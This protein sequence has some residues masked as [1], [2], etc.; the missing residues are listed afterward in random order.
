MMC[1]KFQIETWVIGRVK[2]GEEYSRSRYNARIE[3]D[4][5]KRRNQSGEPTINVIQNNYVHHPSS[6][7]VGAAETTLGVGEGA[8]L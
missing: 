7:I 2:R 1:T 6:P 8:P 3:S 4:A 5:S